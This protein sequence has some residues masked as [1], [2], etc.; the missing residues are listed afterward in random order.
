MDDIHNINLTW[1]IT[2]SIRDDCYP[3][4][5]IIIIIIHIRILYYENISYAS[6]YEIR[7][8][9]THFV[10]DGNILPQGNRCCVDIL[11]DKEEASAN[12]L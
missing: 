6:I 5:V 8:R 3:L 4:Y 2:T 11:L 12:K 10:V 9:I 7:V 1:W